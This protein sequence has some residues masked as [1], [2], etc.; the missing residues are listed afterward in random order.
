MEITQ[1]NIAGLTTGFK[2]TFNQ[3]LESTETFYG[4]VAT[5]IQSN[6]KYEDYPFL[7]QMPHMREW[8]GDREI[9]HFNSYNYIVAN[10]KYESTFGISKDEIEDDQYGKYRPT[11]QAYAEAAAKLPDQ[12]TLDAMIKGFSAKC[13]DEK[14]FFNTQ[15]K[16]GNKTFSNMSTY[17][18]SSASLNAGRTAML[19]LV[20]DKGRSLGIVPNLLVVSPKNERVAKEILDMERTADGASNVDRGLVPWK[21]LVDLSIEPDMWFLFCT[22]KFI[23]PFIYQE[24]K[25]VQFV[26]K[27]GEKD[28][29]VF[30]RDEY[31][32]GASS[33]GAVGYGLWQLA[34]GSTGETNPVG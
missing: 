34:F 10:N 25:K 7:G 21:M 4:N 33:R 19:S 2:A 30:M 6:T 13:Y 23:K 20:G 26:Y 28:D 15:H 27:T 11:M 29:N 14:S 8:I 9:Q 18:L 12:L 5:T 31:L 32:Y 1:A 17:K 16:V 24:R 22:S 3:T